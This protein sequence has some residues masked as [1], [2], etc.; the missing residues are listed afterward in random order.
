MSASF[1]IRT[2]EVAA[3][4]LSQL[5]RFDVY[6][7]KVHQNLFYLVTEKINLVPNKC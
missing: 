6:E 2:E 3:F 7:R 4:K 5:I 1:K